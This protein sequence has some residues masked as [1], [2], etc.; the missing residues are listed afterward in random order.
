MGADTIAQD[1]WREATNK[2][3]SISLTETAQ[4]TAYPGFAELMVDLEVKTPEQALELKSAE[5]KSEWDKLIAPHSIL[6]PELAVAAGIS[7]EAAANLGYG[8]LVALVTAIEVGGFGQLETPAMMI[9]HAPV[10]AA[11]ISAASRIREAYMANSIVQGIG[12]AAAATHQPTVIPPEILTDA[13]SKGI[14]DL[15]TYQAQMLYHGYAMYRSEVIGAAGFRFPDLQSILELRRRGA[16]SDVGMTDWLR[17]QKIP[18]P[19]AQAMVQLKDQVPEPYRL[20]D[21]ASKG[22]IDMPTMYKGMSWFGIDKGWADA[23]FETQKL[24]P[25]IE[26]SM[27]MLRREVI[28]KDRFTTWATRQGYYKEDAERILEMKDVIP[29]IDDLIRF[30]VRE[31]FPVEPGLPQFQQVQ[32]WAGKQGLNEYWVDKYWLAHFNRMG[33]NQAYANVWRGYFTIP[34][35]ENYLLLA[36]VHPDDWDAIEKV[37]FVPPSIRE[38]GYGFDVL[39]FTQDDIEKY[40]MWGGLSPEDAKKS[41]AAMV[42][43]RTEAEK[44]SVRTEYMYAYGRGRITIE[45]FRAQL[46]S[47][48]T[49]PKAIDLWVTRAEMYKDRI[50]KPELDTEGLTISSSEALT[51]YKMGLRDMPWLFTVLGQL[52]WTEARVKLA[53][54]RAQYEL[55]PKEVP[56]G[57]VKY[58]TLTATQMR[59]LY[60]QGFI[61][62]EFMLSVF[63][64]SGYSPDDAELLTDLYTMIEEPTVT[65]KPFPTA[66]ASDLYYYMIFDDEDLQYDFTLQGY[67]EGQAWLMVLYVRLQ[68]EYPM[69][70]KLY[71]EGAITS[72][73]LKIELLKIGMMEYDAQLLIKKTQYEVGADRLIKEK[74][75]TKAEII[76]GVKNN[77]LTSGQGVEL[78]GNIGYDSDE[79][80]YLLQI[81]KIVS[82]GDP[83]SY[84]EMK[85][86]T[87]AY[88]KARGEEVKPIPM[89][90]FPIEQE[91]NKIK[92]ELDKERKLGVNETKIAE[93]ALK[94]AEVEG[95]LRTVLTKT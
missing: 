24:Y 79:A 32:K 42:A 61:D 37:M 5:L 88:K 22:F 53:I 81:N 45:A 80:Y 39:E 34:Q 13:Y 91:R 33:L 31:A 87:L 86:A 15:T 71:S 64:E 73:Q 20:A 55:Q 48:K 38:M 21:M 2:A 10:I 35:F 29:P 49:H 14:I 6:T 44:N 82:A 9:P 83:E 84:L 51:A 77:I 1:K 54:E 36:D 27:A 60:L 67:D 93:L 85:Q 63:I 69:L 8:A 78:L 4:V 25:S 16:L 65:I 57:E 46:E 17:L 40:R 75:L 95:R 18:V 76:K 52:G 11:T 19:T 68:Q 72:E 43:Y 3:K 30:A 90:A 74:D 62:D 47:L 50:Q 58:K 28:D 41:A 89:E 70:R 94:L 23:W 7:F 56:A 92:A 59:T 12:Y 66:V 26:T